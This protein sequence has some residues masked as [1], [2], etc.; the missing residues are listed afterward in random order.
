[1]I[2]IQANYL[3]PIGSAPIKN[4]ILVCNNTGQI[5]AVLDPQKTDSIPADIMQLEGFLVPGFVNTHCHL[6]LSALKGRLPKGSGLADFLLQI[7]KQ[8]Q[9]IS[10]EATIA[11]MLAAEAEMLNE[12]IVAVGDISNQSIS[13]KIKAAGRLRYHTFVEVFGSQSEYAEAHFENALASLQTIQSH[14]ASIVPHATYSISFKL[15]ELIGQWARKNNGLLSIHH[16]ENED[17]NTYFLSGQGAIPERLKGWGI[18]MSADIPTYKRPLESL[19][20]YLPVEQPLLLVHNTTINA[21]DLQTALKKLPNSYFCLCPNANLYIE[22]RLPNINLMAAQRERICIGT[23][24]LSSNSRLSVL[25][26]LKTI[27]MQ[28]NAPA[29]N[30]LFEWATINGARFLRMDTELGSFLKN[31]KPGINLV[32]C[33]DIDRVQLTD[34]SRIRKIL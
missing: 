2:N 22:N 4:G 32:E 19:L 25:E 34:Q 18:P 31:K 6:E 13:F 9:G 33:V 27:S 15:L 26:E 23:D 24:G 21:A 29:L 8:R 20:P 17:E 28:A 5:E 14:P 16:Q 10:V 3:F 12:G 1:M 11:A 30:T 7:Q